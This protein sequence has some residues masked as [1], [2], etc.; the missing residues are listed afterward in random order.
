MATAIPMTP[1]K[2]GGRRAMSAEELEELYPPAGEK[3]VAQWQLVRLVRLWRLRR[4]SAPDYVCDL[5]E[6]RP[7]MRI[8]RVLRFEAARDGLRN[9]G[10]LVSDLGLFVIGD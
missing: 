4:G 3:A 8:E 9:R 2:T 5:V 1:L 6:A 10:H 7:S